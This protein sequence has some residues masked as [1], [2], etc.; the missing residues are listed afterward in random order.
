MNELVQKTL[1]SVDF[2]S[3]RDFTTE[4]LGA[5]ILISF[6][7]LFYQSIY[8]KNSSAI[9]FTAD[10]ADGLRAEISSIG[11]EIKAS[12]MLRKRLEEATV[13]LRKIEVRFEEMKERLPSEKHLSEILE[14]L[15]LYESSKRVRFL[16]VKPLPLEDKG[17]FTRVPFQI[18]MES[19]FIPFGNYLEGLE[20]LQRVMVVDNFRIETKAGAEPFL[21]AQ[22]Y[23]STYTLND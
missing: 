1:G 19:E 21:T 22:L 11:A 18:T 8:L 7:F 16:S 2:A 6:T 17:E 20:N 3:L 12:G 13:N 15:T 14:E 10:R 4:I 5:L 23:L 9:K